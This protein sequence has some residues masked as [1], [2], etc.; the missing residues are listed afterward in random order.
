MVASVTGYKVGR[1][2]ISIGDAHIY[3]EHME[4]V[5]EQLSRKPL[6]LPKLRVLSRKNIDDFRE[7]DVELLDY[8]SY[9][10]IKAKMMV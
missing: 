10:P 4:A 8:H 5:R 6:P 9:E 7:D 2:L 1:V 3:E